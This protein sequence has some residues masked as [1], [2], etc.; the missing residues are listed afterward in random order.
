MY[1]ISLDF[2]F[3]WDPQTSDLAKRTF[4]WPEIVGSF[5]NV[6]EKF[7]MFYGGEFDNGDMILMKV[8]ILETVGKNAWQVFLMLETW[9][10]THDVFDFKL[11][12]EDFDLY[13]PGN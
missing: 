8:E 2:H 5:L 12:G 7:Y 10:T 1:V 13:P 11:G 6:S 9:M 4:L 3:P